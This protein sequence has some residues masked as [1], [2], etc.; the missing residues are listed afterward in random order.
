MLK[1]VGPNNTPLIHNS[2]VSTPNIRSAQHLHV[3]ISSQADR[4]KHIYNGQQNPQN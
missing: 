3:K 2:I 1:S 4:L